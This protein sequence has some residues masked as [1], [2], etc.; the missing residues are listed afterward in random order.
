MKNANLGGNIAEEPVDDAQEILSGSDLGS[1]LDDE[2]F[3]IEDI[4][5]IYNLSLIHI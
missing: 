1:E 2:L 3:K 5:K 4:R